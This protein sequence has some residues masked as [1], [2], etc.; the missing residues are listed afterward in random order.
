MKVCVVVHTCGRLAG[1]IGVGVT[2][3][4]MPGGDAL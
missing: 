2:P 4:V 1:N 3:V